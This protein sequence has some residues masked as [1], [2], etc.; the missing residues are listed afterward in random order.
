MI[1]LRSVPE[2]PAIRL[3]SVQ[4]GIKLRAVSS[5]KGAKGDVGTTPDFS[6]GTVTTLDPGSDATATITGETAVPVLNLGI[7]KGA[8]GD[9]GAT[10][11]TGAAGTD[12]DDGTDGAAATIA[13]GAVTTLAAGE[14][15]TVENVGT[16]SAAVFDFGI[17]QGDAGADGTGTGDV[18]AASSID[19]GFL[20]VGDGGAKG[21]KKSTGA[22]GSAAFADTT[23]FATAA[24]GALADSA[25]Q[26]DDDAV[27][28]SL[29]IGETPPPT[30]GDI[31]ITENRLAK[32]RITSYV[33]D[34]A[35]NTAYFLLQRARGTKALPTPPLAGDAIGNQ[36]FWVY[37]G[38]SPG[39]DGS[40]FTPAFRIGVVAQEDVD[41][42]HHGVTAYFRSTHTGADAELLTNDWLMLDGQLVSIF[43]KDSAT[44]PPI[45]SFGSANTG[46]N[47]PAAGHVGFASNGVQ[48]VDASTG[49][50]AVR[51]DG[52]TQGLYGE[53]VGAEIFSLTRDDNNMLN[54]T[55]FAG[56]GL[57]QDTV[58]PASAYALTAIL[59]VKIGAPSGGDPGAGNAALEG[60]LATSAPVTKT[61]TASTIGAKDS[62]IIFNP[63]AAHTATLPDPTGGNTGRILNVKTIAAFAISSASSNVVPLASATA[64]TA[65]L[66]ATAGKWAR[67]KSDGTNWIIMAAG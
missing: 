22:P 1:K 3:R 56:V 19:D 5:L 34:L 39:H 37:D 26:P 63:S 31:D 42:T 14:D 28:E 40:G 27:L 35:S 53:A 57:G 13:V 58:G 32:M 49:K 4:P 29:V 30:P 47:F 52:S 46:L 38:A 24:Q 17:P 43:G 10:G 12:G 11:A 6:I 50:V 59:G 44:A 25:I 51:A 8:T 33:D 15:A 55:G 54:V 21:I 20:V 2:G 65:I 23:A 9:T 67:L 61:G 60:F 18:T 7:P 16:S 36:D 66:A 41:E 64:G 62:D 48:L 45:A